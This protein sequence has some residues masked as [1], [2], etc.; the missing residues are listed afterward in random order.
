MNLERSQQLTLAKKEYKYSAHQAQIR[1]RRLS[2][3]AR[4]LKEILN[5]M[6][7]P[8]HIWMDLHEA[9]GE[10]LREVQRW[11]Q[12]WLILESVISQSWISHGSVM[13]IFESVMGFFWFAMG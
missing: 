4:G 5:D 6:H 3:V 13:A 9:I 1:W 2:D 8:K 11:G 10:I 7:V 12:S